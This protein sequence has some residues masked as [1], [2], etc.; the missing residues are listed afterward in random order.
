MVAQHES[1]TEEA[2][3]TETG[4]FESAVAWRAGASAG[5]VATGVMGL[6]I[7]VVDPSILRRTIAGLYGFE[8][9]LLAGWAVHLVHGTL[10]GLLFAVVTADPGLYRIQEYYW[11]AVGTGVAY[12]LALAI[13]GSGIIMPIWLGLV[14]FGTPPSIPF[15]TPATVG[16]HLVYGGVLGAVFA[17]VVDR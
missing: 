12:G 6:A 3:A 9:S 1:G 14:G 10:F 16:W 11:K 7:T 5:V 2:A 17:R 15:V 8:G 13:A 4:P